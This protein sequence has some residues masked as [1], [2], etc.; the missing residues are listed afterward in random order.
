MS[1]RMQRIAAELGR[2]VQEVITKGLSDPRV[3]GLV[4]VVG[5]TVSDDLR[6]A[7][8][9]VSVY[10][11]EHEEL[12]LHGLTAASRFIRRE[13]GE[14]MAMARLPELRFKLDQSL[15]RQAGVL[16]ALAK[17][18]AERQ[19]RAGD[20]ANDPAVESDPATDEASPPA[21]EDEHL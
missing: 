17:A 13:A 19:D 16:D 9:R 5:V 6:Q 20:S 4:T 21:R 2:A 1:V 14:L 18:N 10:P 7:T 3:R 15:K 8:V 11:A 12:T